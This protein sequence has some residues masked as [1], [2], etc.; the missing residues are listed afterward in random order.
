MQFRVVWDQMEQCPYLHEQ[1]ARLPLR[2]PMDTVPPETF[3]RM[4]EDGERRSGRMVYRTQCPA[5]HACEPLRVPVARFAP[6]T[7]QRRAVRK[8]E[9][10]VRMEV[11]RPYL[12]VDRL[13]LYNRHKRERGLAQGDE[14]LT[15]IGYRTWLM[16]SF[17][18]TREVR[19]FV[20]KK[21]CAISILDFGRTSVS[22]VYHYFDP[23]EGARSLGVYSVVKEIDL[24]RTLG[25]EWYYLGFYVQACD[26][27]SY[28]ATYW[29]HQRRIAGEWTEFQRDAL[30]GAPPGSA[31]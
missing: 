9:G 25:I 21:L 22:S 3:D 14:P 18:D 26:R 12:S 4:L 30:G 31:E 6:T 13:H 16:D 10:T 15:A 23:D 8:N 20:G 24:C 1:V 28:K 5:C 29:P 7:S 2:M 27:L 17:T 19:Y 11:G